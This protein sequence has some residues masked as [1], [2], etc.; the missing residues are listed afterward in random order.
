M[1]LVNCLVGDLVVGVVSGLVG[2]VVPGSSILESNFDKK[3]NT[4]LILNPSS[5][6]NI[7]L[8]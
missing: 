5:K 6:P 8:Q 1:V 2:G 7:R 3:N 4:Q